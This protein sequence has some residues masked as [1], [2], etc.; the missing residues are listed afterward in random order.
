[1]A[2][3]RFRLRFTFWL[4]VEKDA[5]YE[6]AETIDELKQQRRFSE[7]IRD[8]IRLICD[9]RE[10]R[11]DSLYELFP[12][13]K[14]ENGGTPDQSLQQEIESLRQLLLAQ[15]GLERASYNTEP[16]RFDTFDDDDDIDLEIKETSDGASTSNFLNS[17]MGLQ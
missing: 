11:T 8:G 7:T 5:E 16:D 10:G 12:W 17:L 9:L 4:D 14:I 13:V 2:S 6:L 1:M 3:R 15:Q